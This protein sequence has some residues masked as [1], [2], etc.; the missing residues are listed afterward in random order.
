MSEISLNKKQLEAVEYTDGPLL[1]L[2]GAGAGK[3]KTI[4]ERIVRIVKKGISP[5]HILAVTFT[6]KAAKEMRE[7]ITKRLVEEKLVDAYNPYYDLPT[8]K[9]F[10]GLGL[11]I[12]S[13]QSAL[14]GLLKHPTIV[15]SADSL[16]LI[17]QADATFPW[18]SF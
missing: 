10:H 13:E 2:A 5:K 4:S 14:A 1:I 15:D 9:T 7:R 18:Y 3:T 11:M 6:N 12:L 8:I 16:T 17:K